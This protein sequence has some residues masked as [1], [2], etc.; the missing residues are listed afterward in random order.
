LQ[1]AAQIERLRDLHREAVS[2][3]VQQRPG[4]PSDGPFDAVAR[5]GPAVLAGDFN[6]RADAAERLR[7]MAPIDATTPAYRDAWEVAHA[8]AA[9]AP[10]VGVHDRVQWPGPP[11]ACDFVFV[12]GDIA[13]RVRRVEVDLATDASDHQPMLLELDTRP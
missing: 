12:S 1:R 9:H 5:G 2:Q 13:G 7:L 10:T 11:F 8:G 4:A 6:F 3:A